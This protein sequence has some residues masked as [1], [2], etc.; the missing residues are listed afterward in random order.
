MKLKFIKEE[1]LSEGVENTQSDKTLELT[2]NE[3]E[4]RC[5][6]PDRNFCKNRGLI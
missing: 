4:F 6:L 3:N 2:G 1:R 5:M